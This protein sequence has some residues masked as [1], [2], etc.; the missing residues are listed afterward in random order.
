MKIEI[1]N[2][3]FGPCPIL[4]PNETTE[5]DGFYISYNNHDVAIY[6]SDTTALVV[7]QMEKFYILNGDHR[8][9]YSAL[10]EKGFDACLDYF[11]GNLSAMNEFSD[12]LPG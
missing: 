9:A 12:K 7:G 1:L 5:A 3:S 8:A 6:G 11:A 2:T 4:I 10:I